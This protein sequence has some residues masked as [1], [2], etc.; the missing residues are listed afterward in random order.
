[1]LT[2]LEEI[3]SFERAQV[4]LDPLATPHSIESNSALPLHEHVTYP[5]ID[6]QNKTQDIQ[7]FLTLAIGNHSQ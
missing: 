3:A 4:L 2:L 1:L 7:A 5:L 6:K